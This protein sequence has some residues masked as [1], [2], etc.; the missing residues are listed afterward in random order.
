MQGRTRLI[1]AWAAWMPA[2]EG[3]SRPFGKDEEGS[4]VMMMLAVRRGGWKRGK[5]EER[6]E[7]QAAGRGLSRSRA[8]GLRNTSKSACAFL[9]SH[10]FLFALA[11]VPSF[12]FDHHSHPLHPVL[13]P[14]LCE[15]SSPLLHHLLVEPPPPPPFFT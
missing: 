5:E 7:N 9:C 11:A 1:R 15:S 13:P 4:I 14:V 3:S 6:A 8:F 12:V 2:R 10:L